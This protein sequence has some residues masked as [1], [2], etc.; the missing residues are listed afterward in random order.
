MIDMS[1]A[2]CSGSSNLEKELPDLTSLV[3]PAQLDPRR[4][5]GLIVLSAKP[6][7]L[8]LALYLLSEKGQAI[9]AHQG[10]VSLTQTETIHP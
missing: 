1:I 6:Q 4:L 5:Y 7:A 9:I 8:K 2:Y 3:V 10:L